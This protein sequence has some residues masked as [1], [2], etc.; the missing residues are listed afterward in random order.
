MV[1]YSHDTNGYWY[2]LLHEIVH[3]HQMGAHMLVN[4]DLIINVWREFF[5]ER[6]Y[7]DAPKYVQTEWDIYIKTGEE[8]PLVQEWHRKFGTDNSIAD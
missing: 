2:E 8:G 5:N 7:E 3:G 1:E 4:R 6:E